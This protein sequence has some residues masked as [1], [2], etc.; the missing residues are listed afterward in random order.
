MS[1]IVVARLIGGRGVR[2]ARDLAQLVR[3]LLFCYAAGN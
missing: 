1:G 3:V 2:P